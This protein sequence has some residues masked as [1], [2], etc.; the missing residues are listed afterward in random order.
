[1]A[2]V[3]GAS[4]AAAWCLR[5]PEGIAIAD[6]MIERMRTEMAVVP[7]IFWHEMRNV[8]VIAE[9]R[10]RIETGAAE[11][12]LSRLRN[13]RFV[14]D[15]HQDDEEI[16]LLARRHGLTAYDAAYLET[17]KRRQA[18]F[19]GLD[20]KLASAASREGVA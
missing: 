6:R 1:M 17:A 7:G 11:V 4:L 3:V 2:I 8:L 12:H 5:E 14:T 19:V 13:L 10:N 18:R 15:D 16:L 9:R 20:R